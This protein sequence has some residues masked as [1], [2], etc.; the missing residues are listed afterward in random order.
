M[1]QL[2]LDEF[3]NSKNGRLVEHCLESASALDEMVRLARAGR[4]PIMALDAALPPG[5]SLGDNEKQHVGRMVRDR[6]NERG[7]KVAGQR[8]FPGG[9]VFSSGSIYK[10]S[11]RPECWS[12]DAD[13]FR[14]RL[15]EAQ[16]IVRKSSKNNYSVDD[17]IHDKRTE[18]ARE[19]ARDAR[20]YGR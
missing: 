4:S 5:T 8:S 6:M 3:R 18:A 13:D 11:E 12:D 7:W 15:V 14:Q 1:A 2:T 16:E 19:V 9:R 20:K 10:A 17:F